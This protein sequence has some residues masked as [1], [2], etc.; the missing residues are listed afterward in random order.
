MP[1]IVIPVKSDGISVLRKRETP[2]FYTVVDIDGEGNIQRVERAYNPGKMANSI[3][4]FENILAGLRADAIVTALKEFRA[5]FLR[6]GVPVLHGDITNVQE[7]ISFYLNGKLTPLKP[8]NAGFLERNG[9][10]NHKRKSN[11]NHS[12][13]NH[14]NGDD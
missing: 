11:E 8:E 6:A 3:I 2:V 7:A 9:K 4:R 14:N 1:R 5:E 12:D 13:G 10:M